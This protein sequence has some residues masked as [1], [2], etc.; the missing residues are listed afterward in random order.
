MPGL[1]REKRDKTYIRRTRGKCTGKRRRMWR[2]TNSEISKIASMACVFFFVLLSTNVRLIT[3]RPIAIIPGEIM[4]RL[5]RQRPTK[6]QLMP[7]SC[8]TYVYVNCRWQSIKVRSQK[9]CWSCTFLRNFCSLK[10]KFSQIWISLILLNLIA[11][12]NYG[13]NNF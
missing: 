10:K 5:S 4:S 6:N 8:K 3:H 7:S 9:K 13:K 1:K 11:S 12:H 2:G